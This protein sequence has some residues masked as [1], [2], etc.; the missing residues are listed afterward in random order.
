MSVARIVLAALTPLTMAGGAAA[1]V[2]LELPIAPAGWGV[3]AELSRTGGAGLQGQGTAPHAT[4]VEGRLGRDFA[5]PLAGSA[6]LAV[7]E[8][9]RRAWNP[10]ANEEVTSTVSNY[11]VS[12]RLAYAVG[13]GLRSC[14][15]LEVGW[16]LADVGAPQNFSTSG[17]VL[18]VGWGFEHAWY[19]GATTIVPFVTPRLL[20]LA[21][22]GT[23]R[24]DDYPYDA[25][26]L[27]PKVA[28]GL[29]GSIVLATFF[30]GA[31][32]DWIFPGGD[33]RFWMRHATADET[34]ATRLSVRGGLVF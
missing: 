28:L 17:L 31:D 30:V 23:G 9:D 4:G 24:F 8:Y 29:G 11:F 25:S 7:A 26:E 19:V 1:Q 20:I 12:S 3:Q 22:R 10:D 15:L 27:L 5:G 32:F 34:A 21:T 2:C 18:G 33:P 14:P 13:D 6:G 16:F